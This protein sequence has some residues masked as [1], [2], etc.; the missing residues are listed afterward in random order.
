MRENSKK[1][2][3]KRDATCASEIVSNIGW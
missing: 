1:K 3:C 2:L